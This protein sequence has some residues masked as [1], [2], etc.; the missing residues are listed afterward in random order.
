MANENYTTATP[1]CKEKIYNS[2]VYHLKT[3]D[4]LNTEHKRLILRERII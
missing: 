2:H 3:I 1:T 4:A